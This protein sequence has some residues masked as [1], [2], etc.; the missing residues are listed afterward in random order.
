[1]SVVTMLGKYGTNSDATPILQEV[2]T[3][4]L[5]WKQS[6]VKIK[7]VYIKWEIYFNKEHF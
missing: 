4:I 5:S 1:M 6:I 3:K 7:L 2:Q